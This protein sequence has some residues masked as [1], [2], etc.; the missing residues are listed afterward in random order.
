MRP[1]VL[2]VTLDQLRADCLGERSIPSTPHLDALAAEG[3]RFARHYSQ[4]SPCAPGRASIYTGAYQMNH[5]VVGNGSPLDARFDNIALLARRAGYEPALFGYTDQS[6]DPR[7]ADGPDDPRLSRYDGVLPG[8]DPVLH[9]PDDQGPWLAWL[10]ELGYD[11]GAGPI[12]LLA[13]E[14]ERPEEHSLAAFLTDG[15]I[16]WIAARSPEDGPWFALEEVTLLTYRQTLDLKK[17]V[18]RRDIRFRDDRGRVTRVRFR[19]FVH[20]TL[21]HLA[22]QE[23]SF[24]A[25]NWSGR[26]EFRSAV[27]GQ[28]LTNLVGGSQQ[29]VHFLDQALARR[30]RR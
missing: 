8:F 12:A 29:V 23:L 30:R 26:V 15:L 3:V 22:A 6:I 11:I 27:D 4:A 2:L 28:V 9:V 10:A 5:R 18:L 14:H 17:G 25:E 13:T 20:M 21:P 7:H 19:R 16:D 24:T 1:N